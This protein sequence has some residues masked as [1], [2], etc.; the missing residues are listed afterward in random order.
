MSNGQREQALRVLKGSAPSAQVTLTLASPGGLEGTLIFLC[1][2]AW[3]S[4]P[5]SPSLPGL[6]LEPGG[7]RSG[8]I[9]LLPAAGVASTQRPEEGRPSAQY[10]SLNLHFHTTLV[11]EEQYC[12]LNLGLMYL[13]ATP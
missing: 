1:I 7:M 3:L 11:I 2:V 12:G 4:P 6:F 8:C 9:G 10:V 13:L 5:S